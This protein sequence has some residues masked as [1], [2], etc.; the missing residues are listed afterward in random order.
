[1]QGFND[2]KERSGINATFETDGI[3]IL[4]RYRLVFSYE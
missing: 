1:M 2:L 4:K 3:D